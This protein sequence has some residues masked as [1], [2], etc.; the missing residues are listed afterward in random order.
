MITLT[1]QNDSREH[2]LGLTCWCDPHVEWQDPDTKEIYREGPLVVHNAD[3][4]REAV[5]RLLKQ[6]I[7]GKGWFIIEE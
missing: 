7:E 5:E 4:C 1:P 6:G 2:T 3:D